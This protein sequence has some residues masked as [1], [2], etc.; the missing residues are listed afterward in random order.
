MTSKGF[1]KSWGIEF[2]ADEA[3]EPEEY[4]AIEDEGY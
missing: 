1:A 2:G 3:E 4:I